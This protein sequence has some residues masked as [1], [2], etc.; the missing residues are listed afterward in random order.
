MKQ[1]QEVIYL[2]DRIKQ[3]QSKAVLLQDQNDE[4]TAELETLKLHDSYI[5]DTR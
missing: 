1:Q 4:L 2:V 5:K 3:L